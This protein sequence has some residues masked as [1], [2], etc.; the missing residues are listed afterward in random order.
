M[1][2]K[3]LY[4][5]YKD[6]IPYMFFGVCTTLVNT[7]VYWLMAHPLGIGTVASA[8]IAW[9]DAVLFAYLTNRK[10]FFHSEAKTAKEIAKEIVSFLPAVL[11]PAYLTGAVCSFSLT[12]FTSTT[13]L[14]RY[15]LI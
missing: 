6:M 13:F 2:I 1:K 11:L 10:W 5:K 14:S 7:G 8:V 4:E 9:I 15:W 3:E 12:C